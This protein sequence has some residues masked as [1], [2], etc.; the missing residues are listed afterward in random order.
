MNRLVYCGCLVTA[1][2]GGSPQGTRSTADAQPKAARIAVTAEHIKPN[3]RVGDRSGDTSY[4][5][6][7]RLVIRED[8][9]LRLAG[10][11]STLADELRKDARREAGE[12]SD[13]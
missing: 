8:A 2:V 7:Q 13:A 11:V 9:V 10:L 12:P 1:L 5:V 3:W 6:G 4:A